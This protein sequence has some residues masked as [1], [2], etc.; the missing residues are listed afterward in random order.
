ML[1]PSRT[2][3]YARR[4]PNHGLFVDDLQLVDIEYMLFFTPNFSYKVVIL[5]AKEVVLA[6]V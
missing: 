1:F 2:L 5:L 6:I 4:G 3:N